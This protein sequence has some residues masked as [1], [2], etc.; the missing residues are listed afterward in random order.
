MALW[1]KSRHSDLESSSGFVSIAPD[2]LKAGIPVVREQ[3]GGW[4]FPMQNSECAYIARV[5][6]IDGVSV[7]GAPLAPLPHK[8]TAR[9][10]TEL[11]KLNHRLDFGKLGIDGQD[12]TLT[13]EMQSVNLNPVTGLDELGYFNS[14]HAQAHRRVKEIWPDEAGY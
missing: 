5:S 6:E 10:L 7:I 8:A 14:A 11:M 12:L 13:R 1:K 4:H 2:L 3:D 9:E